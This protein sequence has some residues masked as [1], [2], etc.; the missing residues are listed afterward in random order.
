M[1][2]GPLS[3]RVCRFEGKD[4]LRFGPHDWFERMGDSW[5]AVYNDEQIE[6]LKAAFNAVTMPT[7]G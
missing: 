3:V 4:Y 6:R 5:E 7:P 1:N 2:V